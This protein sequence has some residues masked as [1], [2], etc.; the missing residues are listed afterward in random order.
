MAASAL[1]GVFVGCRRRLTL[2]LDSVTKFEVMSL[3]H[4]TCSLQA[5]ISSTSPHG[6]VTETAQ[7][8]S[9]C[10][11]QDVWSCPMF[12]VVELFEGVLIQLGLLDHFSLWVWIKVQGSLRMLPGPEHTRLIHHKISPQHQTILVKIHSRP[13]LSSHL[14]MKSNFFFSFVDEF[15]GAQCRRSQRMACM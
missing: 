7:S 6:T 15:I 8:V 5:R 1:P 4:A 9:L 10:H 13:S 12:L 14:W 2:R 11:D 3:C